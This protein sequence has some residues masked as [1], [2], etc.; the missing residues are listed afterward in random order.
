MEAELKG[1]QKLLDL[2][3][4]R[5]EELAQAYVFNVDYC[6]TRILYVLCICQ[7]LTNAN[8]V[9]RNESNA[10]KTMK[11]LNEKND[12]SQTLQEQRAHWEKEKDTYER[13]IR[14]FDEAEEYSAQKGM[15][16]D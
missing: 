3:R 7:C 5:A 4:T 2:E 8:H 11:I 1:L 6:R 14:A 16:K 10:E 12:I 15:C 13:R 9:R